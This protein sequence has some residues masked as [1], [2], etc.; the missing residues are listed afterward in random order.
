[1]DGDRPITHE[2]ED[3]LGFAPVAKH[4]AKAI[5]DQE[6]A[7]G[8]VFG[9]EGRWGSGKTSLV[10]LT[11]E[12]LKTHGESAPMVVNFAPWL[13]GDR[14]QLLQSLFDDLAT[15]AVEIDPVDASESDQES[16]G[17]PLRKLWAKVSSRRLTLREK[18]HFKRTVGGKLQ[19]FGWVAGSLGKW[20][21]TA[22]SFGVPGA[23]IAKALFERGSEAAT[24][25]VKNEPVTK[26]KADL[27]EALSH[28][29]RRIVVFVDDLDRLEPREASEVLRLIRVVADLPNIIYVLS[30]DPEAVAAILTKAVQVDDGAAFLEKIVQ[31]SFRVPRPEAFDLRRWFQAEVRKLLL[32]D[33]DGTSEE[34]LTRLAYVVDTFGGRYLKT[35]RDVVRALNSLR[36]HAIPVLGSVDIADIVLLQLVRIGNVELYTWIEEYMIEIA[37]V[38]NGAVI[39]SQESK[40]MAQRLQSIVTNENL[41]LDR[42]W[43]ELSEY[44]PGVEIRSGASGSEERRRVFSQVTPNVLAPFVAASRLGSPQHYRYYF[45]FAEPAGALSNEQARAFLDVAQRSPEDAVQLMLSLARE[46]RPQGGTRAEVLI[47]RINAWADRLPQ[48]AI[49]GVISSL[50]N[51]LDEPEL[52]ATAAFEERPAW[53]SAWR[54]T[55]RLLSRTEPEMRPAALQALFHGRALGWL[56]SML[57]HEIFAH[58][59]YGDRAEPESQWLLTA[60]EF[61]DVLQLML[62]RYRETPPETLINVPNLVSLLYAWAQGTGDGQARK[63]VQKQI[64]TD[65]GLL[66]FLSR[67]RSWAASNDVVSHPLQRR[68]LAPFLDFE[69]EL[70]RL[71]VISSDPE[72]PD[73]DRKLAIELLGAAKLDKEF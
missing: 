31:V 16:D 18:E 65:Q 63:W 38:A 48:S 57:R 64:A 55:R 33:S 26:R 32:K 56:T 24:E 40:K 14:D 25:L 35:G 43:I 58:G 28:L 61:G 72:Q 39:S 44:F 12:A 8:L 46:G 73:A 68:D 5:L 36:L 21:R 41:E 45:A 23:N 20:A 3:R 49:R 62:K 30:Y 22:E 7:Q 9:I 67:A 42:A 37:A 11:I 10:N 59:H 27:A 19:A 54:L 53:Q 66:T 29:S 52:S 13:V 15:A 1:M 2:E 34:V 4:L 70:R 71:E 47:D 17:S 60:Q 6:A 69:Q 51:T 50:A